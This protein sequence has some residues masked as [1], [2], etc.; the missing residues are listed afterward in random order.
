MD[1]SADSSLSS[2][3]WLNSNPFTS[4]LFQQPMQQAQPSFQFGS[5]LQPVQQPVQ[6][7]FDATQQENIKTHF[8][9]VNLCQGYFAEVFHYLFIVA[10]DAIKS[11]QPTKHIKIL[12]GST[13][14]DAKHEQ[15]FIEKIRQ[16]NALPYS[17]FV[18]EYKKDMTNSNAYVV[19]YNLQ[20]SGKN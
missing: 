14:L 17:K 3:S 19:I 16:Y 6:P 10:P 11:Y 12:Q 7:Q 2:M 5:F 15:N 1:T 18:I 4:P 13:R 9:K 20:F 8:N